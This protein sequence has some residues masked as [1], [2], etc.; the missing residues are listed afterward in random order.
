MSHIGVK[1]MIV[2]RLKKYNDKLTLSFF[3]SIGLND[4]IKYYNENTKD[5]ETYN[6]NNDKYYTKDKNGNNIQYRGALKTEDGLSYCNGVE[7][8]S[9]SLTQRLSLIQGELYHYLN[10]GFP[11]ISKTCNKQMLDAYLVKIICNHTEVKSIIKLTS[12]IE[13]YSYKAQIKIAT[14]YGDIDLIQEQDF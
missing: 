12:T 1:Y 4:T 8:V 14:N 9:Q 7:G 3:G 2:R 6:A 13:N 10:E 11:L 5:F